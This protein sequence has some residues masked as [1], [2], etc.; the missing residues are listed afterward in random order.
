MSKEIAVSIPTP[1]NQILISHLIREDK[2][3][4][5]CF[6]LYV[7]STGEERETVLI[8][9]LILPLDGDR[10]VHGNVSFNEVYLKRV[11][12]IAME[13]SMG[14]CFMHSHPFP[15]WQSM[16]S[17]DVI[18]ESKLGPTVFEL[19]NLPLV[20]M[21]VGNDGTWSARLWK[22]NG[23][24]LFERNWA[25]LVKCV[26]KNLTVN[27][28]DKMFPGSQY[29]EQF[30]RT[31][32]VYG[33]THHQ[34]VSRLR[35]GI[36]G[37]GSVGSILAET[38][39]RMGL[40]NFVLID[41]DK[42]EP[43]NLDRQLG[44]IADDIGKN[45]V[46]VAE[47]L[48]RAS[49][50]SE[51]VSVRP[52]S[53]SVASAVGYQSALDCDVIFSCVD[54]P[55]ARFVLNHIAYAH[56]IPVIDGGIKVTFIEERFENVEWQLQTIT[57]GKPCL[58]CLG[59]Y[60]PAEV[61]LERMGKLDDPTYLNGLPINHHFRNNENIFPFSANLAS[62]EI[63]QFISLTTQLGGVEFGVQRFRYVHGF[64]SNY[65]DITCH[66]SCSFVEGT[67]TGDLFFCPKQE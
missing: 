13:K 33:E 50:T 51:R 6:A 29:R 5:L 67:G 41:F 8:N 58:Q 7:L 61:D 31:R 17:D 37:L 43:H 56:L 12:A 18:A 24:G 34:N 46:D 66:E 42:I 9:Q 11:C 54:R 62:M 59:I 40:R 25:G 44:A 23:E 39:A 47:R 63:F 60:E 4:D 32:T 65:Q 19:T 35:I 14:I 2:Q 55:H 16:S 3:E 36:V 1:L 52:I 45:K 15:G 64:I 49:A 26:G 57:I 48:I 38:L 21:T 10:Q 20:G 28:N 22:H 27:F 30:K 53:S